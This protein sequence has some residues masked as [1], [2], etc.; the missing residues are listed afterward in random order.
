[1]MREASLAIL[2]LDDSQKQYIFLQDMLGAVMRQP[3]TLDWVPSIARAH[4]KLSQQH[5]DICLVDY[6]LGDDDETGL[7]FIAQ[8]NQQGLRLPMILLTGHGNRQ[9]DLQAMQAGAMDYLDKGRLSPDGLERSIRYAVERAHAE[10]ALRASEA[11]FRNLIA[12]VPAGIFIYQDDQLRYVNDMF[13]VLTDYRREELIGRDF[14][15]LI[16]P[17]TRATVRQWVPSSWNGYQPSQSEVPILTGR[18]KL[19]WVN[20]SLSNIDYEGGP[21]VLGAVI[22]ISKRREME[23]AEQEQRVLAEALV[24]TAQVLNSTL[25]I[26]EVLV[27]ILTNVGNVIQHD[28]ANIM[29]IEEGYTRVVGY[30]ANTDTDGISDTNGNSDQREHE[31]LVRR[32]RFIVRDSPSLQHMIETGK[33]LLITDV[34]HS[35]LTT[36]RTGAIRLRSYLGAP[37]AIEGT[38]IGFIN[39]DS[40]SSGFFTQ[41][42]AERLQ[43]FTNQAALAIKN[44]QVYQQ[45]QELAAAE[46]RQRL[47]RDLHDAVSQTLFSANVMAET[48]PRLMHNNQQAAVQGLQRLGRLTKGALAEMRALLVELRPAALVETELRVL[49]GHLINGL[50]ARCD[51]EI[52]L[53]VA[54]NSY[55]LTPDVQVGLYRIAQEALNNVLK[56]AQAQHINV[57]L[58]YRP[59]RV[60][61]SVIDDGVGFDVDAVPADH[62]GVHIMHERAQAIGA[63]LHLNSQLG[64]GTSLTVTWSEQV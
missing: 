7:D 58:T 60:M 41:R 15:H 17:G 57:T 56:H 14:L 63:V 20:L 34:Q 54:G 25:N 47:A 37:I 38:V 49:L 39:L 64:E 28:T 53:S 35:G 29:L 12:T 18:G 4:E 2:L 40:R 8:I 52:E 24:D 33:P 5:Y 31:Q 55:L 62:M 19:R 13:A 42:H 9:V 61:L 48:L 27:R 16:A 22:D 1:M 3:F 46:E 44:A 23:Q 10:Q 26:N 32:L 59:G 30:R 21:A 11:R 6:D 51:C 36:E 45:A 43:D 50:R